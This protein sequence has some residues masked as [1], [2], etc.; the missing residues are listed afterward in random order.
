MY[1]LGLFRIPTEGLCG[2][3]SLTFSKALRPRRAGLGAGGMRRRYANHELSS[4]KLCSSSLKRDERKSLA[5]PW[6][7][8]T[9][10][11]LI[12]IHYPFSS[13]TLRLHARSC[14][15]SSLLRCLFATSQ[16][17][18]LGHRN[19]D[20]SE[21]GFVVRPSA[22]RC[23]RSD[24]NSVLNKSTSQESSVFRRT[25]TADGRRTGG[26]QIAVTS[27]WFRTG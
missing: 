25:P 14:G 8:R 5:G 26:G 2:P 17:H 1:N 19:D 11:A 6:A 23:A 24:G 9:P 21:L 12:G 27:H 18:A 16:F 4:P 20:T 15:S 13:I 22:A 7:T 10:L 3:V